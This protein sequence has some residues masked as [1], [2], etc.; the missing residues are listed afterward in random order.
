[1]LAAGILVAGILDVCTLL[2]R[3]AQPGTPNG[4]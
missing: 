3:L 4:I 2:E 1:L